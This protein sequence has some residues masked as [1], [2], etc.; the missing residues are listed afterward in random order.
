MH[1]FRMLQILTLFRE[2]MGAG[3]DSLQWIRRKTWM[4]N[5]RELTFS[6]T[7][8]ARRRS[9][10]AWNVTLE[11]VLRFRQT[12]PSASLSRKKKNTK[13]TGMKTD[14]ERERKKVHISWRD[15]RTERL[16]GGQTERDNGQ[17]CFN[18]KQ[19]ELWSSIRWIESQQRSTATTTQ[20]SQPSPPA[21]N[22]PTGEECSTTCVSWCHSSAARIRCSSDCPHPPARLWNWTL[23]PPH[24]THLNPSLER[25]ED[26]S[27]SRAENKPLIT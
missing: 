16:I 1:F 22:K 20:H 11:K 2:N 23:T 18:R 9:N 12:L 7:V 3:N 26:S 13:M 6:N 19:M 27:Y 4:Q 10:I 21:T 15:V 25:K 17:T 8:A 24:R 5:T 14:R